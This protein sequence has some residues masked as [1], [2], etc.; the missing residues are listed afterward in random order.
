MLQPVADYSVAS[1]SGAPPSKKCEHTSVVRI[2]MCMHSTTAFTAHRHRISASHWF[3]LL[4]SR[5]L[6]AFCRKV[7]RR[8]RPAIDCSVQCFSTGWLLPCCCSSRA[9]LQVASASG[10]LPRLLEHLLRQI[11]P[12]L[13][14]LLLATASCSMH[15]IPR[16]GA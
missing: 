9:R 13:A 5:R 4:G 7:R 1:A 15:C 11:I 3:Q 10:Q 14:C 8:S 16:N 2:A 6:E 12:A